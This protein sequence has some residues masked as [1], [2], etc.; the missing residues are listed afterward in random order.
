MWNEELQLPRFEWVRIF[1]LDKFLQQKEKKRYEGE[2]LRKL[3][4]GKGSIKLQGEDA[5]E[6]PNPPEFV[7]IVTRRYEI[8]D[9]PGQY[10]LPCQC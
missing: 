9:T 6:L 2:A 5:V 3:E 10:T 8:V 1:T 7:R 4:D